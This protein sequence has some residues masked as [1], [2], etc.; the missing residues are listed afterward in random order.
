MFN[1]GNPLPSKDILDLYDNSEVVDNFVNSQQDEVPD[2]FGTKRLTLSGLI[3]RSMALRNEIN[4]FSGA[5][6]FKPEWSDVPMNVSEGVG[7]EGGAL[8]LQAEALGNRS[9]INKVTS[10]EALRRSYAEAGYT[11]VDGS[12]E[13]GGTL[14]STSDA[15]L[16]ESAGTAYSWTGSYPVGGYNVAPGIDPTLHGSGYVSRADVVLRDDIYN[17]FTRVFTNVSA[18]QADTSVESG[19]IVSTGKTVWKVGTTTTS[20]PLQKSLYASPIGDIYTQDFGAC[21]I[22]SD[23]V[24]IKNA[25]TQ[26][27]AFKKDCVIT[28]VLTYDNTGGRFDINVSNNRNFTIKGEGFAK[29]TVVGSLNGATW[30]VKSNS[31]NNGFNL[32]Y[33]EVIYAGS[34]SSAKFIECARDFGVNAWGGTM[35]AEET[36]IQG[37]T[38]TQVE[39]I[40]NYNSRF[41]R[42][43]FT[44]SDEGVYNTGI[45]APAVAGRDSSCVR[46]SGGDPTWPGPKSFSN[47]IKFEQ[48]EFQG[49]K[50]G[51]EGYHCRQT[52][53]D[54]CTFQ[55]LWI[56]ILNVVDDING[57]YSVGDIT[58]SGSNYWEFIANRSISD[59][60]INDDGTTIGPAIRESRYFSVGF[61]EWIESKTPIGANFRMGTRG[62]EASRPND[63]INERNWINLNHS[64]VAKSELKL[65]KDGLMSTRRGYDFTDGVKRID[66]DTHQTL[67]RYQN[68]YNDTYLPFLGVGS[69]P[70][71]TGANSWVCTVGQ[72]TSVAITGTDVISPGSGQ[73]FIG[74]PGA[75]TLKVNH[76]ISIAITANTGPKT[77]AQVYARSAGGASGGYSLSLW[78]D[79]ALTQPLNWVTDLDITGA[80]LVKIA[81]QFINK[82]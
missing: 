54:T 73:V 26:A 68:I 81:C 71:F 7:G 80:S 8:N 36:R 64:G 56:G 42:C 20:L 15:M 27:I 30:R 23:E 48:C 63:L 33:L 16:L 67:D 55:F 22:G 4:D 21:G 49:A 9:E 38:D 76:I 74:L 52:D 43:V 79:A 59:L 82:Q 25:I 3:K 17:N 35:S 41:I 32:N 39:M 46:L 28:G 60:P 2:R 75:F 70:A 44:G 45:Y 61:H 66:T 5:L 62:W 77:P 53:V 78:K 34:S 29:L 51:I 14:M 12:F 69:N 50:Y 37:F 31:S 58:L 24:A 65:T 40:Q 72:V 57:A 47:L 19:T 6:T 18:M 1:T 13:T 11:L 10:R